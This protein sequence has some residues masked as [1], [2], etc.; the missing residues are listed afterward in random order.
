MK[1]ILVLSAFEPEL[2]PLRRALK[3]QTGV[4]CIAAGIGAVD[5]AVGAA[6]AI[7]LHQP[8]LVLFTGTAGGYHAEAPVGAVVIARRLHLVSTAAERGEGY[9]P[10]PLRTREETNRAVRQGLLRAA[11][12]TAAALLVQDVATPLAITSKVALGRRLARD[13]GAGVENLEAFAVARA[14]ARAGVPFGAV[15]GISNRVGPRAHAEWVRHQQSATAAACGVL[16]AFLNA[17][18]RAPSRSGSRPRRRA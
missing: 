4:V 7:A 17:P 2:T 11:G 14:A 18:L 6:Q 16:A 13:S 12:A 15:L 3:K 1:P 8:R 9:L 5:A 10:A